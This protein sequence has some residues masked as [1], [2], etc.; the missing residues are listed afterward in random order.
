MPSKKN[1]SQRI[2][3]SSVPQII[4]SNTDCGSSI[5]VSVFNGYKEIFLRP[6][7]QKLRNGTLTLQE[8]HGSIQKDYPTQNFTSNIRALTSG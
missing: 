8:S 3:S 7:I 6:Y 5:N 2:E 4:Y 1:M